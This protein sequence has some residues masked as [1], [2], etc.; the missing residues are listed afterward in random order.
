M[1]E[2][3]GAGATEA[4][5]ITGALRRASVQSQAG[6]GVSSRSE[7]PFS[8]FWGGGGLLNDCSAQRPVCE[9]RTRAERVSA[10]P[11]P[12]AAPRRPAMEEGPLRALPPTL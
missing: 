2:R 11:P 6:V 4:W 10:G 12:S 3:S 5:P 1:R 9:E 7:G 8:F